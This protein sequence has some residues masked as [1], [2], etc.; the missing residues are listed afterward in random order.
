MECLVTSKAPEFEG[1]AVHPSFKSDKNP[2]GF[3]PVKLSDYRGKWLYL[4]FYPF[5]FTF[6]C[7]TELLSMSEQIDEFKKRGVE[8]LGCSV[9]SKFSHYNW[10]RAPLSEGGVEG[11]KYPLLE[12]LGGN[13]AERYG[14]KAGNKALR[15]SFLIDPE[16]V[17][18]HAMVN[19]PDFGRS[20]KEH[21]RVVDAAQFAA[22]NGEV[23][24]MDWEAGQPTMK[25]NFESKKDYFTNKRKK[26]AGA[27]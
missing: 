8:I 15:A 27:R 23:C 22:K 13:V 12:D 21:L 17:I 6:V 19:S 10:L 5:D 11:L 26:T 7:P 2:D 18:Q 3:K 20:V 4:F 24:P 25:G 14:V 16:G 9:D 1:T